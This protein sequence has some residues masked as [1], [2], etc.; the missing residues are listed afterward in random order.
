MATVRAI[1]EQGMLRLLEPV[2]LSEGQEV[3]LTIVPAN[4]PVEQAAELT[5]EEVERRLKAAG[6]LV[7]YDPEDWFDEDDDPAIIAEIEAMTEEELEAMLEE[8]GTRFVGG[9][10]IDEYIDEDRGP[11]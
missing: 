4:S 9:R 1:Y 7:E 6:L 10:S 8:I 11:R 3:R 2:E 5:R